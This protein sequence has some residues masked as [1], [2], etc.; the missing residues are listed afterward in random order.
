MKIS[1]IVPAYNEEK[2][3]GA[4]LEHIKSALGG[5]LDPELIVVD[6]ESTD[7]TR[8]I[9]ESYGATI[10]DESEHN[11]GLVRNT[12]ARRARGDV[13]VFVDA[14]TCV[15]PRLFEKI[16]EAMSDESCPG[17]SV[18]V[19]Y[20]EGMTAWTSR[21]VSLCQS[22]GRRTRIRQGATQFCRSDFFARLGGY[23]PTIWVGE[24]VEFHQRLDRLARSLGG[25]TIFIEEP[26]V[27]TSSRR[28][29]RFGLIK[30]MLYTHP[31]MVLM[32]WRIRSVW[33]SWY[34]N[35]VR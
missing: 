20:S 11:I 30:T 14:D 6:N 2:Y 29:A 10:V 32:A 8:Q 7:A 18:A 33:K 16:V 26:P 9:A 31:I 12:G 17:G 35:P 19:E 3:L 28:F 27:L 22:I 15:P 23:D 5:L 24:D 34:E 21:Y 1:V 13:I 25:R 4:T